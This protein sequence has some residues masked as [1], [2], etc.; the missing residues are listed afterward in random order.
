M[1]LAARIAP[2]MLSCP[3]VFLLDARR[4]GLDE[5][6]LRSWARDQA[7]ASGAE[8]TSRS[9]RY[10][11]AL[12]ACHEHRVGVDIERV[13]RLDAAFLQSICTPVERAFRLEADDAWSLWCSKEALAKALGDARRYDPRR[14][15]SPMLWPDGRSGPWR[16]AALRAPARHNAWV[17][18]QSPSG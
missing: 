11:Y 14:L 8:Y 10:P 5:T 9:Y 4:A 2:Q 16:A 18:W 12:V 1:T 17:C 6:D 3:Q 15:V 7:E 13:E